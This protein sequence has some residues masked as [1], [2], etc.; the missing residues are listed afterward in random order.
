MMLKDGSREHSDP[1]P[2]G[3]GIDKFPHRSG[4]PGF[5]IGYEATGA[6]KSKKMKWRGENF[7]CMF[8]TCNQKVVWNVF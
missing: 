6:R 7:G 5:D 2:N 8:K 1:T 4:Q 3:N